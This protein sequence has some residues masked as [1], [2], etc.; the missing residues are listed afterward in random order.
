MALEYSRVVRLIEGGDSESVE[1]FF[2]NL[3]DADADALRTRRFGR[4][5]QLLIHI[6]SEVGTVEILKMLLRRLGLQSL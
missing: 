1:K 2:N 3:V 5:Q 4:R 6:V